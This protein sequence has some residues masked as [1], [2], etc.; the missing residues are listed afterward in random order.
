M[1]RREESMKYRFLC[2]ALAFLA[3]GSFF[4][5]AGQKNY[6]ES[7]PYTEWGE[8][9]VDKLLKDSPW[10]KSVLLNTMPEGTSASGGGRRGGDEMG[11]GSGS[12]PKPTSRLVITW[13]AR[14]IREAM[15]RRL[16][17]TDPGVSK[18]RI[19]KLLTPNAQFLALL[20][21]GWTLARQADRDAAVASFK[22]ETVLLKKNK[23]KIL[24]A[25]TVFPQKRDDPLYLR[26]AREADGKPVLTPA[27][28]EV[29]LVIRVGED[30]YRIK[31][32]LAEMRIGDKLEL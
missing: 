24:L 8:K 25:D 27:D 3:C 17:L 20:V 2:P 18:E 13:V 29:T 22:K 30:A 4:I 23:E 7:K 21:N 11:T 28:Q 9:E 1:I 10:T 32:K 6:W 5:F 26:F 19:D 12:L 14:P 15:A 16:M 31:F